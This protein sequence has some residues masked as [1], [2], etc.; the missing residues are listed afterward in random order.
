M[1]RRRKIK[2][3]TFAALLVMAL[4]GMAASRMA[5]APMWAV[6]TIGGVAIACVLVLEW[7]ERRMNR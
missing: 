1:N 3:Q 6:A 4:W 7:F 2:Y 5:G